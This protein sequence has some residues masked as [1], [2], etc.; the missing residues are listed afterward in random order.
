MMAFWLALVV[1][2]AS[3]AA[4]VLAASLVVERSG[5]VIGGLVATLPISAGPA[6]VFLALDHSPDF[7]ARSTLASLSVNVGTAPFILVYAAVAQRRGLLVSLGAGLAVWLVIAVALSS[8]AYGIAVVLPLSA[9]S[10]GGAY[11]L[12]R[13]YRNAPRGI[14]ARPGAWDMPARA[15][16]VMGVVAAVVLSGR[17]LGPTA[18]GIA[19]LLPVVL[20]SLILILH[21]R[22]GGPATAAVL[23]NSI[24]GMIGFTTG[25]AT[26]H[27]TVVPLGSATALLLALGVCIIW[28]AALL[29]LTLWSSRR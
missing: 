17:W 1:K 6:L 2:M 3:S 25:L 15:A 8:M 26:L 11:L 29:V 12:S 16:T 28:N 13:R 20:T 4:I 18:A 21:P 24:P 10:Y 27:L 5:P 14:R 9:L 7:L 22:A 19:A 23:A